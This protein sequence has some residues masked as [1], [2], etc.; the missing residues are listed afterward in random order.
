MHTLCCQ[1]VVFLFNWSSFA[2][3]QTSHYIHSKKTSSNLL[4]KTAS[5]KTFFAAVT[6]IKGVLNKGHWLYNTSLKS[7]HLNFSWVERWT[8]LQ[9]PHRPYLCPSTVCIHLNLLYL[10]PTLIFTLKWKAR[11]HTCKSADACLNAL[12][13]TAVHTLANHPVWSQREKYMYFCYES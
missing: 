3:N 8:W 5:L 13:P 9:L 11:W 12:L 2:S 10:Q 4:Y 1:K 6:F 7:M